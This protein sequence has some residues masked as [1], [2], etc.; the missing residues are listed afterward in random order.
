[1][2]DLTENVEAGFE[3]IEIVIA[4]LP[5][6]SNIHNLS[7]LELEGTGGILF[8]F[9][10]GAENILKQILLEVKTG[11]PED[12][13]WH[14]NILNLSV[15]EN[16]ISDECKTSLSQYLAFRNFFRSNYSL[17]MDANQLQPLVEEHNSTYTTFRNEVNSFL[18]A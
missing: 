13:S 15:E 3:N 1:M 10:N 6:H 14:T 12:D 16:I 4:A 18:S 2:G 7:I 8:T 9:Y 17:N 11:L 5:D